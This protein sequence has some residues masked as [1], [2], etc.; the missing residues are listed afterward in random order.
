MVRRAAARSWAG[1]DCFSEGGV[2]ILFDVSGGRDMV[3]SQLLQPGG[4]RSLQPAGDL[5]ELYRSSADLVIMDQQAAGSGSCSPTFHGRLGAGV[6]ISI[7][8]V[9]AAFRSGLSS[10]HLRRR[11]CYIL[12]KSS[13]GLQSN[14]RGVRSRGS[15]SDAAVAAVDQRYETACDDLDSWLFSLDDR[16]CFICME[17]Y[18]GARS[19]SRSLRVDGRWW[20]YNC[21][22]LVHGEGSRVG[23]HPDLETS[24][25]HCLVDC[26]GCT[27]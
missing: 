23:K 16:H 2:R 7:D 22:F 6:S 3:F 18:G 5:R 24:H 26:A 25:L 9:P 17:F 10:S 13:Y 20:C 19:S 8:A 27:E 4:E 14:S 1:L 12:F 11:I 15:R 21:K